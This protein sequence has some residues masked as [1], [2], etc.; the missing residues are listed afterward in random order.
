MVTYA[1]P[2]FDYSK[3][4]HLYFKI[5]LNCQGS[6]ANQ[7]ILKALWVNRNSCFAFIFL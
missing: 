6:L 3:F 2:L 7:A 1:L 5:K 4:M